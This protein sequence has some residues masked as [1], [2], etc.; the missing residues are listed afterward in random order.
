MPTFA[1]SARD[2]S[3]KLVTGTLEAAAEREVTALLSEKSLFPVKIDSVADRSTRS[4]FGKRKK[5]KGQTL[6]VFFTQLASL[7]RAGVPMIRSLNVLSEQS[8]DPTLKEVVGE[9]R[10]HVRKMANRSATRWLG[11]RQSLA[12]WPATWFAREPKA[13]SWRTRWK[14]SV[15][16][17]NCKRT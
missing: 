16:L 2:T 1:Y 11:I 3:G 4:L 5:I 8:T 12:K 10:T 13:D 6:A 17:P 14:E 9:I 7:L 15:H